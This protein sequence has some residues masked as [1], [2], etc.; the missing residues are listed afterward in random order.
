LLKGGN[1]F[2]NR[3]FRPVSKEADLVLSEY[4]RNNLRDCKISV[5]SSL[6]ASSQLFVRK[7]N[8]KLDLYVDFWQF[9]QML[10]PV[11]YTLPRIDGIF[12]GLR[13]KH[14]FTKLDIRDAY[15]Q[16][17]IFP[18]SEDATLFYLLYGNFKY[19]V[20]PFGLLTASAVFQRF[21]NSVL[22]KYMGLS[23]YVY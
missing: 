5:S 2:K 22:A 13:D 10:L 15:N 11:C 21:K 3:P 12:V 20:M 14:V 17:W 6:I 16:I 9:N 4:L 18:G 23:V 7:K 19:T 8:G 1:G